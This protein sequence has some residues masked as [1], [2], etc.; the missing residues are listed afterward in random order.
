MDVTKL[1]LDMMVMEAQAKV[2]SIMKELDDKNKEVANGEEI[3]EERLV[4]RLPQG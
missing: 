2:A 3:Q 1:S 4:E